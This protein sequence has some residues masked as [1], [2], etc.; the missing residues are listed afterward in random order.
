M[1]IST[2]KVGAT[3][4]PAPTEQSAT[5]ITLGSAALFNQRQA[6]IY[7]RLALT[8]GQRATRQVAATAPQPTGA[9]TQPQPG[10]TLGL[11]SDYLGQAVFGGLKS[12]VGP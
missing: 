7:G 6:G 1:C 11:P 5:G 8:G 9:T 2:P 10:G 3:S 4:L 12:K